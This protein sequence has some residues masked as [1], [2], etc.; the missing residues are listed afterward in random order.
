MQCVWGVGAASGSLNSLLKSPHLYE[1][2]EILCFIEPGNL[3][4]D[5]KGRVLQPPLSSVWVLRLVDHAV[6]H[7]E[8][9]CRMFGW[10]GMLDMYGMPF[11]NAVLCAV[12]RICVAA[13]VLP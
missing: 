2:E 1:D 3:W 12:P 6:V 9:A 5:T 7:R 10:C 11:H 13:I 4:Q 8:R